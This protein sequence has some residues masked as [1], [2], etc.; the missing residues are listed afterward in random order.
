MSQQQTVAVIMSRLVKPR[1]FE[2]VFEKHEPSSATAPAPAKVA[3]PKTIVFCEGGGAR[4]GIALRAHA[5]KRF[6]AAA[7]TSCA[8]ARGA[9]RG[10]RARAARGAATRSRGARQR[11]GRDSQRPR[12]G[13][14]HWRVEGGLRL[15][16]LRF[17]VVHSTPLG[18]LEASGTHRGSGE[19]AVHR[20]LSHTS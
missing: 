5:A 7:A 19:C 15:C 6:G 17:A 2:S 9:L 18:N 1:S 20:P 13:A 11:G 10:S 12:G 3:E 14:H 16:L 4:V 8:K